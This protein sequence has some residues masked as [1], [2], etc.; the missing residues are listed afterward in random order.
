MHINVQF[1]CM[2]HCEVDSIHLT[3]YKELM[4]LKKKKN[5]QLFMR[6]CL[7]SLRYFERNQ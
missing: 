5:A 2:R 1:L 6:F 7:R 3:C 4:N